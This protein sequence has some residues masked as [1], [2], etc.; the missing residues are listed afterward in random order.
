MMDRL[1][2]LALALLAALPALVSTP[3]AAQQPHEDL[4]DIGAPWE[5]T[6]SRAEAYQV[7]RMIVHQLREA[8]MILEDPELTQYVQ[9]IGHKLAS[10]ASD[11]EDKFSFF[12]VKDGSINAFALPGGFIGVNA[13]LIRATRTESELAGVLA[14]EIAHVTQDHIARQIWAQANTGL[15]TTAAMIAAM[16]IGVL[17]GAGGDALSAAVTVTQGLSIQQQ[18]THTRTHEYEADRVG[19]GILASAGFDPYGMPAFFETLGRRSG[20]SGSQIPE[21]LRTHPLESNRVAEA[22]GR[23]ASYAVTDV[24]DSLNYS[25]AKSRLAVTFADTPTGAVSYFEDISPRGVLEADVATRYGYAIALLNADQPERA[26]AFFRSLLNEQGHVI[27]FHIGLA[28]SLIGQ[29]EVAAG[30]ETFERASRLFPRNVPLTVRYS[31]AL[32]NNGRPELAH[33]LMLDLLNSIDYDADQVRLAAQ[34][35]SAAGDVGD[36]HYYMSEYHVVN[37]DLKLAIEQLQIALAAPELEDV[38]RERFQARIEEITKVLP[39]ERKRRR[40]KDKDADRDSFARDPAAE[41]RRR[42]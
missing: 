2:S 28:Q 42:Y 30:F 14:H 25:L 13:G 6:L 20:I 34:A 7:G 41:R 29:G 10:R 23:A 32:L 9:S 36:A 5:S 39:P 11:G 38:Q 1:K 26:E 4:P 33:E 19:I 3:V 24:E 15:A 12:I 40:N 16:V 17:A 31:R 22:R 35:A 27:A 37:G 8:D 18:I 21:F